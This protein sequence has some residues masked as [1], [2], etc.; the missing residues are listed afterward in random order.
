M[1][2]EQKDR[3]AWGWDF[4]PSL[5][6]FPK[7]QKLFICDHV[8]TSK[9]IE[10]ARRYCLE[11]PSCVHVSMPVSYLFLLSQANPST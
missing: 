11:T 2:E 3:E 9:G 4:V 6:N 8:Q 7:R 10:L 5:M 1:G